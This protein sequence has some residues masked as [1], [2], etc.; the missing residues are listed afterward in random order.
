MFD[1]DLTERVHCIKPIESRGVDLGIGNV[2]KK[3]LENIYYN[4]STINF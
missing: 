3:N 2:N 4:N 1:R